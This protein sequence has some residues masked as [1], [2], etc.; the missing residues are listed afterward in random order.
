MI[1]GLPDLGGF[2]M[3]TLCFGR[4]YQPFDAID[5][6]PIKWK[7]KRYLVFDGRHRN[8]PTESLVSR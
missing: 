2:P 1:F 7:S 3:V 8:R 5:P 4:D 6:L